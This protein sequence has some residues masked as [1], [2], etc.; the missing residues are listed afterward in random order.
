MTDYKH[1]ATTYDGTRV[2][3][4]LRNTMRQDITYKVLARRF[5]GEERAD[6]V[7]RDNFCYFAAHVVDCKGI[8]WDALTDSM[9]EP[10]FE[11]RYFAFAEQFDG[12]QAFDCARAVGTMKTPTAS[13][14]E[15]PDS[16]L[17]EA[18]NADPNS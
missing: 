14:I 1:T 18:E 10:E 8:D 6:A 15:K 5:A 12:T 16:A 2:T 17:T 7:E 3:F 9:K 13:A 11:A 4:T